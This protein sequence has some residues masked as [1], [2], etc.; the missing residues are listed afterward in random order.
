MIDKSA[1]GAALH[2]ALRKCCDSDATSLLYNVVGL[3]DK[4]WLDYCHLALVEI[5]KEDPKDLVGY[6]RCLWMAA[7]HL[8]WGDRERAALKLSMAHLDQ[9]DW[10]GMAAY[11]VD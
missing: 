10:E 3:R 5:E 7:D 11:L 8:E 9:Q 1:I 6:S 2:T 4:G